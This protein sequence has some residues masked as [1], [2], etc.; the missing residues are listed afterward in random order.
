MFESNDDTSLLK[1]F[2]NGFSVFVLELMQYP[3]G[4]STDSAVQVIS[5]TDDKLFQNGLGGFTPK[6]Y[7]EG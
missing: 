3:S 4:T 2:T 6:S 1:E 5:G 7:T